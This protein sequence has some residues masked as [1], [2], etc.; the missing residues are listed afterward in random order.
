M[1]AVRDLKSDTNKYYIAAVIIAQNW[2]TSEL[3]NMN[4]HIDLIFHFNMSPNK[5]NGFDEASQITLNKYIEGV[6]NDS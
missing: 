1:A 6:L 3:G 4:D 5:F 2:S